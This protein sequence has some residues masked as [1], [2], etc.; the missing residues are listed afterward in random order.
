MR[1][2]LLLVFCLSL[3]A[4]KNIPQNFL[5]ETEI[6]EIYLEI[7]CFG[8]SISKVEAQILEPLSRELRK[9]K[10]VTSVDAESHSNGGLIRIHYIFGTPYH[11]IAA[12]IN[13]SIDKKIS[14]FPK[15]ASRPILHQ[16]QLNASPAAS[17]IIRSKTDSETIYQI[18]R[19]LES[20]ETVSY[21][22][23]IGQTSPGFELKPDYSKLG[24]LK[25]RPDQLQKSI[26]SGLSV[27]SETFQLKE[28]NQ[29]I[30]LKLVLLP[31][32]NPENLAVAK[33]SLSELGSIAP[34][35]FYLNGE[36]IYNG[37]HAILINLFKRPDVGY[38]AFKEELNDWLSASFTDMDIFVE[39]DYSGFIL[40]AL[41][42][43]K[44]SFGIAL[45]L[46][47]LI[48]LLFYQN[49][50]IA[51][52]AVFIILICLSLTLAVLSFFP[53][54]INLIS[55][56]GLMF[57][58]GLMI[59]NGIILVD[60]LVAAGNDESLI[61]AKAREILPS[62]LTSALTSIGVFIPL[63]FV[64]GL[65]GAILSDMLK[66]IIIGLLIS[67]F[68]VFYS[69]PVIFR[70][71][72]SNIP[73]QRK[74]NKAYTWYETILN[75]FL[76]KKYMVLVTYILTF[77]III[78]G[79]VTLPATILPE[80]NN[81][82]TN[83]IL[84]EHF[85]YDFKGISPYTLV[86]GEQKIRF[87]SDDAETGNAVLRTHGTWHFVNSDLLKIADDPISGII[88]FFKPKKYL[89]NVLDA[90]KDL[91]ESNEDLKKQFDFFDDKLFFAKNS[92]PIL[93]KGFKDQESGHLI[94]IEKNFWIPFS[95]I[96]HLMPDNN[97]NRR[98]M[99]EFGIFKRIPDNGDGITDGI[100]VESKSIDT[101]DFLKSAMYAVLILF[102]ALFTHFKSSK[103]S[104]ALLAELPISIAGSILFLWLGKASINIMS[105]TGILVS[106][107]IVV[108]DSIIKLDTIQQNK[109]GKID[110]KNAV[111]LAG[112]RRLIPIV[113][114]TL[115]TII[116]VMPSLFGNSSGHYL[117]YPLALSIAGGMIFST[118]SS[119]FILPKWI[120]ILK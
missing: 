61:H 105:M 45:I 40:E 60:Q 34:K 109:G 84:E 76:M 23:I 98:Y 115:T 37:E 56:T 65:I 118:F 31:E 99:N 6:P 46:T 58:I 12:W 66:T 79:V 49:L 87:K 103:Y 11:R 26:L 120:L 88:D 97:L 96:A 119:L 21:S 89:L 10:E 82:N 9:I 19:S 44:K 67:L 64:P 77:S 104:F 7:K 2:F 8:C 113:L 100:V 29:Q 86:K 107:G 59:D 93:M 71:V 1:F 13:E 72:K 106:L 53:F 35:E 14:E 63:L 101:D 3:I 73:K 90:K 91:L 33:F 32:H 24:H 81:E 39:R 17:L 38:S 111:L 5:P 47:F 16:S 41:D 85:T 83:W 112:K 42:G 4:T 28:A 62:L 57:S 102:L 15:E 116:A 52:F 70:Q 110:L 50:E 80:I 30:L 117:Q 114:T 25:I 54:S 78:I 22:T 108:N 95:E 74:V 27:S 18:Q 68:V 92:I 51:F 55:L 94:E 43:L 69:M 75:Q 20:L 36:V 48:L